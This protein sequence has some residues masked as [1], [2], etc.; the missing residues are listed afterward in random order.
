MHIHTHN[1]KSEGLEK[2]CFLSIFIN[3][4]YASSKKTE[5]S[6]KAFS[7]RDFLAGENRYL[8]SVGQ[9]RMVVVVPCVI[10]RNSKKK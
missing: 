10:I 3:A 7:Q 9:K 8:M 2:N 6:Q 1:I 5:C 4:C